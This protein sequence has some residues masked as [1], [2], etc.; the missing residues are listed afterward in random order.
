MTCNLLIKKVT[1]VC[2]KG[3]L[4][5]WKWLYFNTFSGNFNYIVLLVVGTNKYKNYWTGKV[6]LTIVFWWIQHG[7]DTGTWVSEKKL[8]EN[9]TEKYC[10]ANCVIWAAVV[11]DKAMSCSCV[12]GYLFWP[13]NL[14]GEEE[15]R[16]ILVRCQTRV[17]S[18]FF[19]SLLQSLF[20]KV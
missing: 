17:V 8:H 9:E 14:S 16:D 15:R 2:P 19:K 12:T 10:C 4:Y 20:L 1:I 6:I 13:E 5:I 11:S 18:L 7:W 3:I